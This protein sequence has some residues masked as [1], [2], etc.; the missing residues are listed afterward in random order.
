MEV[1]NSVN[2]KELIRGGVTTVG[3]W[4]IAVRWT[5]FTTFALA[6]WLDERVETELLA[7]V[8]VTV[9]ILFV[10]W[11]TNVLYKTEKPKIPV[12]VQVNQMASRRVLNKL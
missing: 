2:M 3:F 10:I 6:A 4:V 7:S 12:Q 1:T 9:V 8:V 11:G 5:D